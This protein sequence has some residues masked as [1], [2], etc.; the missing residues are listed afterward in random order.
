MSFRKRSFEE[1]YLQTSNIA[2]LTFCTPQYQRT[3]LYLNLLVR[4]ENLH[5]QTNFFPPTP[6]ILIKI[7]GIFLY[8]FYFLIVILAKSCYILPITFITV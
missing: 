4:T 5:Q 7:I 3:V 1:T 2:L 6:I 8:N